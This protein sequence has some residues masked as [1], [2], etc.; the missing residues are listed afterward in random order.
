MTA[1]TYEVLARFRILWISEDV[2]I[3]KN[4]M[5][6]LRLGKEVKARK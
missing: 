5:C 4:E 2:I 6:H 3:K 1:H